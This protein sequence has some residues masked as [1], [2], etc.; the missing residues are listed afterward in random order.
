MR[1]LKS[2]QNENGVTMTIKPINS[3]A[4][5]KGLY[6]VIKKNRIIYVN[7]N[8]KKSLNLAS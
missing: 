1:K 6:T 3:A 5:K 4:W 2:F 7:K 8:T